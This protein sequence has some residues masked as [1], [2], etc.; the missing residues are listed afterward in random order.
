MK[1]VT[2]ISPGFEDVGAEAVARFEQFADM[3]VTVLRCPASDAHRVKLEAFAHAARQG[4]RVFFDSDLWFVR[5]C[6]EELRQLAG[7]WVAGCP[8]PPGLAA[9]EGERLGYDPRCRVTTGFVVFDPTLPQ[10]Q[11]AL[12]LALNLQQHLGDQRDEVYLNA[13]LHRYQIPIRMIDSGWNWCLRDNHSGYT[14]DKIWSIHAAGI[15][16]TEKLAALQAAAQ[17]YAPRSNPWALDDTELLWLENFARSQCAEGRQNVIEFG[18]GRSTHA[19]HKAGCTVATYE[20]NPRSF[21][22]LTPTLP[23]GVTLHLF[24][25]ESSLG[26]LEATFDWAFV[27]GPAGHLLVDGKSRWHVLEWCAERC[28]LIVLHD[29][30]RPGEEQS[31]AALVSAGWSATRVETERGFC[32]LTRGISA[33]LTSPSH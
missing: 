31:I 5:P 27:D 14:S 4:W 18:P 2:V 1:A 30:K 19:L 3:K 21:S 29:A 23:T 32:L 33:D 6:A 17:H 12:K 15:S 16:V 25:N 9:A 24:K 28:D 13:A 7:P 20:T 26:G 22:T 11:Q 10:W 8:I